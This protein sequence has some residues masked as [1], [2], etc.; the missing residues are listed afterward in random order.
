MTE[1]ASLGEV[2]RRL[3][4]LASGVMRLEAAMVRRETL[5]IQLNHLDERVTALES[6]SEWLVRLVLGMIV[7]GVFGAAMA[8]G[9]F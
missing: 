3:D 4:E 9:A 7:S 5:D 8:S 2:V 6:R 1:A